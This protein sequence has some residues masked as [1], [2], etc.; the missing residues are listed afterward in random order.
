MLVKRLNDEHAFGG[1]RTGQPARVASRE[2][3][4]SFQAFDFEPLSLR[5][6]LGKS[7]I[8]LFALLIWGL[9]SVG[10][11]FFAARRMNRGGLL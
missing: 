8:A 2:F 4:E 10:Y 5:S 6:L 3:Y 9:G 1:S 11:L 7:K